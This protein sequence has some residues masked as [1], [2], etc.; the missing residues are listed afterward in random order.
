MRT[1]ACGGDVSFSLGLLA[2]RFRRAVLTYLKMWAV[3]RGYRIE[4]LAERATKEQ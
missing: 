2:L 3:S 4:Q 1:P